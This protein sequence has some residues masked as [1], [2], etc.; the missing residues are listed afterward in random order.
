MIRKAKY[1]DSSILAALSI[2]VWLDTYAI[3]GVNSAL[4]NYTLSTFHKAYFDHLLADSNI[5]IWVY[6]VEEHIVGYIAIDVSKE[7]SVNGKGFE[8]TTLYVSRHFQGK[9][10]GRSL[11]K[12]VQTDLGL[13]FWLS[14][15]IG[16]ESALAFYQH[17]GMTIEGETYFELDNEQHKNL[18]LVLNE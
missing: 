17:I 4:A 10:V 6:V 11:L 5:Q 1:S 9:G 16:N 12:Q 8:V 7:K 2:Q 13:P 14:V 15:W 3:Y 18:V